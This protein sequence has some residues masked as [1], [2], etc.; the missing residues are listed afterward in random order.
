MNT[1]LGSGSGGT[2]STP[3]ARQGQ[4]RHLPQRNCPAH[5]NQEKLVKT[6]KKTPRTQLPLQALAEQMLLNL[7]QR[8][9][10]ARQN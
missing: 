9:D 2:V 4:T 10:Y 8:K 6:A 1:E 7:V 5:Q 3:E